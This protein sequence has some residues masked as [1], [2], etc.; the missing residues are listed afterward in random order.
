MIK[1]LP[2]YVDLT[3]ERLVH[4]SSLAARIA[5]LLSTKMYNG[6]RGSD[7][8]SSNLPRM[9]TQRSSIALSSATLLVAIPK[10]TEAKTCG[11]ESLK[12][13]VY[14]APEAPDL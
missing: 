5:Y 1:V 6:R 2:A 10:F 12:Q 7:G 14:P 4:I 13:K 8:L 3:T 9:S 11:V